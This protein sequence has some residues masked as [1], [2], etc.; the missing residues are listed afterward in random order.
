MKTTKLNI[1]LSLSRNYDKVTLEMIEEKVEY[2]TDD[3]LKAK[4]RRIL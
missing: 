4:V 3:D 2:V 1:G